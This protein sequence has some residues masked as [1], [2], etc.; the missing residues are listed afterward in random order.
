[1]RQKWKRVHK[2]GFKDKILLGWGSNE[3]KFCRGR[4]HAHV[5]EKGL[6]K[7]SGGGGSTMLVNYWYR[8]KHVGV[9]QK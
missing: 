7:K 2:K 4:I 9:Y 1:M 3:A 6:K 5:P 8:G